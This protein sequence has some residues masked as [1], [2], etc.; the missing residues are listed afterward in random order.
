L[1]I[2]SRAKELRAN[3]QKSINDSAELPR[4]LLAHG[5]TGEADWSVGFK[6]LNII[7][8]NLVGAMMASK[9]DELSR[10]ARLTS[11]TRGWG[12]ELCGYVQNCWGCQFLCAF[13]FRIRATNT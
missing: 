8:D 7:E 5:N 1:E 9:S 12:R 13:P 4:Y 10:R 11:E 6:H 2:W 3:W